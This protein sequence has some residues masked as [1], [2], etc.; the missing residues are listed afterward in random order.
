MHSNKG[1]GGNSCKWNIKF[2]FKWW[3]LAQQCLKHWNWLPQ[4]FLHKI[5]FKIEASLSS[6]RSP[7]FQVLWEATWRVPNLV[8]RKAIAPHQYPCVWSP[9]TFPLAKERGQE[10]RNQKK[11]KVRHWHFQD[12]LMGGFL[13]LMIYCPTI[14]LGF[15][16]SSSRIH[17]LIQTKLLVNIFLMLIDHKTVWIISWRE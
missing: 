12:I 17:S 16:P 11:K 13:P 9:D 2:I 8:C 6:R 14:Y 3:I 4:N 1:Q 15:P 7:F 5:D 10:M